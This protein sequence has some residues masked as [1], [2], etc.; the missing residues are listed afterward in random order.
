MEK[1]LN[2]KDIKTSIIFTF[3][4]LVA[5]T[6]VAIYQLPTF[7]ESTK[8]QIVSQIGS[9]EALIPV[10]ALQG[11]IV[12][13]TASFIG[14]KLARRV[15]LK[16]NFR[17]DKKALIMAVIIGFFTALIITG[18]DRFIFAKYLPAEITT[19]IFS[20]VYLV[21]GILYGGVVEEILLRLL[22]MSLLVLIIWKIFAN[23]K[24]SFSIPKWIYIVSIILASVLFAAGHIPFT[25]QS[26][27][28]SAPIL[29]RCFVLNG[30]GGLGFGYLY[31]KKGLAY[32]MYAHASAHF[33]MQLV[34]MPILFNIF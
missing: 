10:A 27:G 11:M 28:L 18:S 21:S 12:T 14:L 3:I 31:W 9:L 33:F 26:I 16:L 6:F 15:N 30:I 29:I 22:I 13:F 19:Y 8:L 5:S 24:D 32:S 34:L 2:S 20:P 7:S 1:I 25:A 17:F 23:S 4:G